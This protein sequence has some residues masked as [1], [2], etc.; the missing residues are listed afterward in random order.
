VKYVKAVQVHYIV[1][2]RDELRSSGD[3]GKFYGYANC[4]ISGRETIFCL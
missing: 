1:N 3:L 2:Y 4:K